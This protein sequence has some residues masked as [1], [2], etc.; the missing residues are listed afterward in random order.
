MALITCPECGKEISDKVKA[1]PHCGYPL[2]KEPQPEQPESSPQQ[3]EVVSVK[4]DPKKSKK[5]ITGVIVAI[6]LVAMC[7]VAVIMVN[8][9][10]AA[11]ARATYIDN[12]TLAR[13]TMLT[14]GA[15]AENLCN[16]TKSV[17]YNT[18]YEESDSTTDAY[19][20]NS[21]SGEFHDDFNT[22]LS[23]LYSDSSTRTT[24]TKIK[25]N[26]TEVAEIMRNL[27]NPPDDL[28]ACFQT[29]ESMYDIYSDFTNL[30]IS[31][32]GTL[33]SHSENFRTY[34][35]DFMRLHDKLDTQI[36]SK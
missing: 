30:A 28:T 29:V 33:Q 25:Q 17:W 4:V 15:Q 7:V 31:P 26:Q 23:N 22:S 1:C 5:I 14:G 27:Q 35:N 16:L 18:I 12:L 2:A 19:T 24:I 10:K 8:Q 32:S 11:A 36:P 21:Y 34:D 13:S 6:V 3:V 9:Q 20:K